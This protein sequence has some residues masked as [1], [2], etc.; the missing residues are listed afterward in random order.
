MKPPTKS[1]FSHKFVVVLVPLAALCLVTMALSQHQ[2]PAY[3]QGIASS[4][5]AMEGVSSTPTP[6]PCP[7]HPPTGDRVKLRSEDEIVVAARHWHDDYYLRN[8]VLDTTDSGL[9]LTESVVYTGSSALS[10]VRRLSVAAADLNGDGTV[11]RVSAFRDNSDRLSAISSASGAT[12]SAWYRDGD[13]YKGE[14]VNWIDIDSGDLDRSGDDEEVVIAFEDDYNAIHVVLLNGAANGAIAHAVNQDYGNWTANQDPAGLGNVGY[15]AVAVGDLNGDGFKDEIVTVMKDGSKHL[16]VVI[17]RRNDDGTMTPLYNQYWTSHDRDNVAKEELLYTNYGNWRPIDVTTG[18]VDG[19]W[20]DE[21][22]LGFRTGDDQSPRFQLLALKFV[23]ETHGTTHLDDRLVMDDQVYINTT[24]GNHNPKAAQTVSLSAGDLDGDGVDEIAVGLGTMHWET[25]ISP[26]ESWQPVLQTFA[27]IPVADPAWQTNCPNHDEGD[28]PCFYRTGLFTGLGSQQIP[29]FTEDETILSAVNVATGELDDDGMDEIVLARVYPFDEGDLRVYTFNAEAGLSSVY[30]SYEIGSSHKFGNFWLDLGDVNG[31]SRY[32]TYH[33]ICYSKPEMNIVSVIHA[34]PHGPDEEWGRNY[35]DAKATFGYESSQGQGT[36]TG[37]DVMIGGSVTIGYEV[38][39]IGP[40]FTYEWE[41]SCFA[42]DQQTTTHSD[43]GRYYTRAPWEVDPAIPGDEASFANLNLVKTD[44]D[45][46]RYTEPTWGDMDV[47]VPTLAVNTAHTLEWWYTDGLATYPASWVPVGINLAQGLGASATQSGIYQSAAASRAVDGNTDGNY[48]HNSVSITSN[49][50]YPWWQVDLGGVQQIDGVQLWNRTDCC[51][52]RLQNFY[53]FV[54]E[55]PFTSNDPNQLIAA[56]VWHHHVTADQGWR[57]TTTVPVSQRGRYLRV[58]LAGANYLQ[59]AEVQVWGWPGEPVLWPRGVPANIDGETFK[60]TW[61]N[62]REQAVP[63]QIVHVYNGN[64]Q[65]VDPGYSGGGPTIGFG[66]ESEQVVG[67]S[68]SNKYTLGMEVKGS[69]AELSTG[70][71]QKNA[72]ILSWSEEISFDTDIAGPPNVAPKE[73]TYTFAPYVW[74]Q[75][76]RSSGGVNQA[77]LVLDYW[78]P[79]YYPSTESAASPPVAAAS[80]VLTPTVPLLTS[81]THPDGA[82]WYTASTAT[83]TWAQPAGDPAVIAGYNW[84]L[85]GTA[86]TALGQRI[87]GLA[88]EITYTGLPDGIW[89]MHVRAASDGGQ[90]SDSAHRAIRVDANAPQVVLTVDPAWPTGSNG[91]YVTPLTVTVA[92]TDTPGSGVLVVEFSTDGVAW[93]PYSAPLAFAADTASTTVFARATDAVGHTSEPVSTTFKIDGTAPDSHVT[94]GQG[95]GAWIATVLTNTV[96]NQELVLAGAI[97]DDLSGRSGMDLNY[98]GMDWTSSHHIGV[99]HPLPGQPQIEVNWIYTATNEFGAGYHIF[100]GQSQDQAG[101]LEQ[102]Y[103][104]ARVLKLPLGSPDLG[105][106]SVTASPG[107]VRPGDMVHFVL[108]ARNAGWQDALVAITNTL[109]VGLTPVMDTLDPSVSYDPAAHTLTWPA[110]LLWPGQAE[111]H[112]FDAQ[113]SA[114]VP[115]TTLSNQAT[116]HAFWPNTDLLEPEQRQ[117]FTDR[118]QTVTAETVVVVDPSLPAGADFTPPWVKVALGEKQAVTD[119]QIHLGIAAAPDARWMALREWTPDPVSGVWTVAHNSGWIDYTSVYTWTLSAGQGVKYLGLWVADSAGNVSTL[120]EQSLV[121]VNRLDGPQALADG[122][123]VQYRG[124]IE[125][126]SWVLAI[127][128]TI[129]GD[130]D[131]HVWRPH[132]G[133]RPDGFSNDTVLPGQ[134]EDLG[135]RFVQQ[136]GRILVEIQ[137]AG[138]SEYELQVTGGTSGGTAMTH[139]PATKELPAHPLTISDPLSANQLGVVPSLQSK[140]Y[141]PLML[142]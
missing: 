94:G 67:S 31:D 111:R 140:T 118:E 33:G 88:N 142:R 64:P 25:D 81:P 105:G 131:I 41:K 119:P 101:N 99:W 16:H 127:L 84:H 9:S 133:Y 17:L 72:H 61:R 65:L 110:T 122:E 109:P 24:L 62:G 60:I 83:F 12:G 57:V 91:W 11:E 124:Y 86:D 78:V 134:V 54:S 117:E 76:A 80:P 43:G 39:G 23:Q 46:Y 104:I 130:P 108:T 26:S 59:L 70:T 18:D 128:R 74:L 120:D 121:F 37:T 50:A 21:A 68:T 56:G 71:T 58:Q 40:S 15:V 22:I 38:D 2:L 113:V 55:E 3:S 87:R 10:H 139:A 49:Q 48:A 97:A 14:N 29:A 75:E 32:G 138:A 4:P 100:T 6:T 141:L 95:P 8:F 90:W 36:V 79:Q 63:G 1:V 27:Y 69:S 34:P 13:V 96:G 107:S 106:S 77:F 114:G 93:Q 112:S 125:R 52:D 89:H 115:A 116:F 5:P 30:A 129:S 126:G 42:E 82:T 35:S 137:A 28:P 123:R 44:Y 45:C 103:E 73:P 136:S 66:N 51:S 98:N 19:D 47:C 85:D 20:R 7:T 53:V 102:P 92:A 135:T 132:N